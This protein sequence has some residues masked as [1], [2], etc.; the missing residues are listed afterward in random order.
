MDSCSAYSGSQFG[1]CYGKNQLRHSLF[2]PDKIDIKIST[3]AA[4]AFV[5]TIMYNLVSFVIIDIRVRNSHQGRIPQG[6]QSGNYCIRKMQAATSETVPKT[7][8]FRL[9][10]IPRIN[11]P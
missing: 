1:A 11:P 4:E 9:V 8:S 3:I 2:V 7:H 5:R 10:E 6:L